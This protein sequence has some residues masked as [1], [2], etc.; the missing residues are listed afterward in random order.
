MSMRFILVNFVI[1]TVSVKEMATMELCLI[2]DQYFYIT[3]YKILHKY[4]LLELAHTNC[5]PVAF[6]PSLSVQYL[7]RAWLWS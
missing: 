2:S 1:K 3:F 5:I 4:K 6:L 7:I